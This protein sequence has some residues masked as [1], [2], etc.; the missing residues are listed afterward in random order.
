MDIEALMRPANYIKISVASLMEL[1]KV[2]EKREIAN[3]SQ[4]TMK[5]G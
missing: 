3:A 5:W 1:V 2:R 4:M